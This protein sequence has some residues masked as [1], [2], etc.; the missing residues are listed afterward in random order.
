VMFMTFFGEPRWDED[1]HPHESP[2]VMTVPL[3]LLAIGSIA[4]GAFLILG[5]RFAKFL[6][7]VVGEPEAAHKLITPYTA[8]VFALM[9]V[10]VGLAYV[11]YLRRP[12]PRTAPAGNF[13]VTFARK[14]LYGDALNESLLMR[15]GQWLTRLTVYFDNR[16]VD[17]LVNGLAAL[18][19]GTS[20][21]VR[22]VQT[23]FVRSYAL[24]MFVGAVLVV[25]ALF[26]VRI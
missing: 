2:K 8:I 15:P 4:G 20:G 6:A 26:L 19:G 25:G 5:D 12:I 24:S 14:D 21:R 18:I 7:P 11:Q 17:G 23:G 22:R 16:G 13:A 1:V 9:V 3:I 10:G